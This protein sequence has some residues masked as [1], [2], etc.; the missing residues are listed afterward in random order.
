MSSSP[1]SVSASDRGMGVADMASRCGL[2]PLSRIDARCITPKRCCSSTTATASP[3]MSTSSC[4]SAWVP[5]ATSISPSRILA[6]IS[7]LAFL[8]ML[9]TS[10]PTVS[11]LPMPWTSNE[12]ELGCPSP[13]FLLDSSS[14][15]VRKCCSARISVGATSAPCRPLTTASSSA[16]AATTVL[17]LPTSPWSSRLIGRLCVRSAMISSS[18]RDWAPVR[19]KGSASR[20]SPTAD[21]P[22]SSGMPWSSCCHSFLR[23]TTASCSRNSSSN[24]SLRRALAQSASPSG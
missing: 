16:A 7:F 18:T 11:G 8:V 2:P 17:P 9:P 21:D 4:S 22:A 6:C 1:Y 13:P 12:A 19:L 10:R 24:A 20:N 5:T 23:R 14:T 15:K 3:G